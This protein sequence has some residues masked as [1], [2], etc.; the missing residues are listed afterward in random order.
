[1]SLALVLRR[2]A[3]PAWSLDD[4]VIPDVRANS[5]NVT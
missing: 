3:L 5:I 1:M 4:S 2:L